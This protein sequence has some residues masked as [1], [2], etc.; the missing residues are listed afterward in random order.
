MSASHDQPSREARYEIDVENAAEMARLIK[1]ARLATEHFGLLPETLDLSGVQ[2]IL[3]IGCGPG[4]WVLSVARSYPWC[5]V[6]GIDLSQTMT[7]YASYTAQEQ[8]IYNVQFLVGDARQPLA[9][10]DAS[11]DIVN[12]RTVAGFLSTTTWP[13]LVQECSRLLRPGGAMCSTE[14]ESL[15]ITTSPSL[16]RFYSLIVRGARMAGQCFTAEGDQ[17]GITAVQARL[18]RDA[19]FQHIQQQAFVI[20]YSAG[21]PANPILYDDFRTLMKLVQPFLVRSGLTTQEEIDVLYARA[22][23]EIQDESFCAVTFAQRVWGMKLA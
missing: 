4:E 20:N 15:G 17:F 12:A 11:F 19:G 21:T 9:F 2:N 23:A 16:T 10:P 14:G 3:D 6:T 1:Q 7:D 22:L 5:Q 13:R 8:K 18:L